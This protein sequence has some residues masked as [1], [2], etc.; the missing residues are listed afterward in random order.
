MPGRDR[1]PFVVDV[2]S[3]LRSTISGLHSADEPVPSSLEVV[4]DDALQH[5]DLRRGKTDAR[6]R[7]T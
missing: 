2:Q 7:R 6:R 3:S 1:Q 4:D 5:A